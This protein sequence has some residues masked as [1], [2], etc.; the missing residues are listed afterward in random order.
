MTA[1]MGY[2]IQGQGH[3]TAAMGY[4]VQVQGQTDQSLCSRNQ[5]DSG[6]NQ[7]NPAGTQEGNLLAD[8]ETDKGRE[9]KT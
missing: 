5:K 3:M 1:A 9:G 4:S 2:G 8:E 6:T 7:H